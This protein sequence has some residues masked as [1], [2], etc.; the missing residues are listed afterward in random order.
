MAHQS[1]HLP[2]FTLPVIRFIQFWMGKDPAFSARTS[3]STSAPKTIFLSR[4][5]IENSARMSLQYFQW[6]KEKEG[7]ILCL[8]AENVGGFMVLARAFRADLDVL[9]LEPK[10]NP[11]GEGFATLNLEK[12]WFVSLVPAQLLHL[13]SQDCRFTQ[14]WS[15]ILLGGG[16]LPESSFSL[17]QKLHCP[18]FQSFGMTETVSHFAVR[19]IWDPVKNFLNPKGP[20]QVLPGIEIK[21]DA[22]QCLWVKGEIT[23]FEW[24]P[25]HDLV[26]LEGIHA[27]SFLG[28]KDDMI[29]S[30]GL[31]INPLDLI[32]TWAL[33]FPNDLSDVAFIGMEDPIWGQKVVMVMC[34]ADPNKNWEKIIEEWKP[35]LDKKKFP[36]AIYLVPEIPKTKTMKTDK[37]ALLQLINNLSPV[38][39]KS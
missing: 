31:K 2:F 13:L 32:E 15:G 26:Q 10:A 36:K 29:N 3:G 27:F 5:K 1:G 30:G 20:Y 17:V 39:T 35:Y 14:T 18:V 28:R 4:K 37:T 21:T 33:A 19:K 9:L 8:P 24:L 34:H 38:W 6:N 16:A 12:N 25:T 11:F 22:A 23:D 7:F